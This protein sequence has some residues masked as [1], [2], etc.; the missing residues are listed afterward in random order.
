MM[1]TADI[2]IVPAGTANWSVDALGNPR[3]RPPN[4]NS[5]SFL[6]SIPNAVPLPAA[7]IERMWGILKNYDFRSTHGHFPKLDIEL[8]HVKERVL[9]SMKIQVRAMGNNDCPLLQET[10]G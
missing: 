1:M 4:V 10:L 8:P 2:F 3:S 9:D 5:Y 7:E 6:W